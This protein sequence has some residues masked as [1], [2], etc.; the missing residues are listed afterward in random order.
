VA[1]PDKVVA[2][3]ASPIFSHSGNRPPTPPLAKPK[4][5]RIGILIIGKADFFGAPASGVFA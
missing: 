4:I 3:K 2:A 1:Q 5:L